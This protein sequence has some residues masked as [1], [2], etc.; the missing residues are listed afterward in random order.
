MLISARE[1]T[2]TYAMGDQTV[3]AL[4]GVD[5][6]L[7]AGEFVVLLGPSGSGKT[8]LL[9]IIGCIER[10]TTGA[11]RINNMLISG[12]PP[13]ALAGPEVAA[14]LDL[15]VECKACAVECPSG[16][17]MAKLKYEVLAQRHEVHGVPLRDRA[18]AHIAHVFEMLFPKCCVRTA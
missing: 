18:F 11:V 8:S 16:V 12:L 9:N 15:C 4:R 3:H 1:L 7:Y 10:P 6:V 14:A 5:L 13:D 2:K 17:D